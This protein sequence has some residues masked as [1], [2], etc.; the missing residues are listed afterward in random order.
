[1]SQLVS[2]KRKHAPDIHPEYIFTKQQI[3]KYMIWRRRHGDLTTRMFDIQ[4]PPFPDA[5]EFHL[6]MKWAQEN[7]SDIPGDGSCLHVRHP[8][9]KLSKSLYCPVCVVHMH[10][11]FLEHI[12]SHWSQKGGPWNLDTKDKG[13][14]H[15]RTAW[16]W[17][18]QTMANW[19]IALETLASFEEKWE[20]ANPDADV[21]QTNSHMRALK[22]ANNLIEGP[23]QIGEVKYPVVAASKSTTKATKQVRFA[24][25]VED[26]TSESSRDSHEFMRR[27]PTYKPGKYACPDK[28]GWADLSW[29]N[30]MVAA[31][32]STK[33][34]LTDNARDLD[35]DEVRVRGHPIGDLMSY[36][37][38]VQIHHKIWDSHKLLDEKSKVKD[39]NHMKLSDSILVLESKNSTKPGVDK[40]RLFTLEKDEN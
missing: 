27:T 33:V 23:S 3:V 34:F 17:A 38:S 29:K 39:L 12:L 16:I 24:P 20:R 1:M 18:R 6:Y 8:W 11:T 13:Y 5:M 9:D 21:S 36:K 15:L 14:H 10:V 37:Y 31:I 32:T 19:V 40:F 26:H 22:L 30:S 25:G 2:T 7:F 35:A 28:E 4:Q